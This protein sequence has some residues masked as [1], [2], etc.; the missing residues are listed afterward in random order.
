MLLLFTNPHTGH[1][2]HMCDISK[3]QVLLV[4]LVCNIVASPGP[5]IIQQL[6]LVLVLNQGKEGVI[7]SRG[8][9]QR[10]VNGTGMF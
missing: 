6:A 1:C 7:L 8:W 3:V 4:A 2:S 9:Y 10:R 5:V